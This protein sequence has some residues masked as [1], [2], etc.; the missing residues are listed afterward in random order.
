MKKNNGEIIDKLIRR[1]CVWYRRLWRCIFK[2]KVTLTEKEFIE[3]IKLLDPK[4]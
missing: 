2:P 3:A 4:L 1:E